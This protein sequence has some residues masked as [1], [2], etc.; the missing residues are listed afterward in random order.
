MGQSQKDKSQE[1]ERQENK[2]QYKENQRK[3]N[4]FELVYKS[5]TRGKA[6]SRPEQA[7]M[8]SKSAQNYEGGSSNDVRATPKP[9]VY[10]PQFLEDETYLDVWDFSGYRRWFRS[11]GEDRR[12]PRKEKKKEDKKTK[13][14]RTKQGD[15][16]K[17]D[18][19]EEEGGEED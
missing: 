15:D 16:P 14:K 18:Q 9:D 2:R 10:N 8:V 17:G 13:E 5:V 4:N 6:P 11:T 7:F 1:D 12:N 3:R 19:E